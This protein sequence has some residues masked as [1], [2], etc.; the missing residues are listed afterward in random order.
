MLPPCNH[1]SYTNL[2]STFENPTNRRKT[3]STYANHPFLCPPI[4]PYLT[5]R[6]PI[7]QPTHSSATNL[8]QWQGFGRTAAAPRVRATATSAGHCH[9]LGPPGGALTTVL[10]V[11]RWACPDAP[12]PPTWA[13]LENS[14]P[15][16][17]H[18]C[19]PVLSQLFLHLRLR[20]RSLGDLWVL[21]YS[22]RLYKR[23]LYSSV[24]RPLGLCYA[25]RKNRRSIKP[26]VQAEVSTIPALDFA[27]FISL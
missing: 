26:L 3:L 7:P 17:P 25:I 14:W 13:R 9:G 22:P 27:V 19:C 6:L 11:N 4:H 20:A 12:W 15:F 1:F 5:H 10:T 8:A 21:E 24:S 16:C 2:L 18:A 23:G